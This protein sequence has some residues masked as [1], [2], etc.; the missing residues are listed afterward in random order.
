[1]SLCA[2]QVVARVAMPHFIELVMGF[3]FVDRE[4]A[5]RFQHVAPRVAVCGLRNPHETHVR[6]SFKDVEWI[7]WGVANVCH[8]CRDGIEICAPGEYTESSKMGLTL[9]VQ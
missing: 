4:A 9:G 2:G 6:E 5:D 3:E 1:M 8:D 7:C